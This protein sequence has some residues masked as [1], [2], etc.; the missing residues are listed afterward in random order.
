MG[1]INKTKTFRDHT[2]EEFTTE[3]LEIIK[4]V[5][6]YEKEIIHL[7][8]NNKNLLTKFDDDKKSIL[9]DLKDIKSRY[10]KI[11]KKTPKADL[12][13]TLDAI[14]DDILELVH[15]VMYM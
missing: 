1:E 2:T 13:K 12:V 8:E 11:N 6:K 3:T 9:S 5:I 4:M 15:R 10:E 14:Y 7:K